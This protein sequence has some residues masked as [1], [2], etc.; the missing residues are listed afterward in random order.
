V[1]DA[2]RAR[3]ATASAGT[4]ACPTASSETMDNFRRPG[5]RLGATL[6]WTSAAVVFLTVTI[7][8]VAGVT[9]AQTA[10]AASGSVVAPSLTASGLQQPNVVSSLP[11]IPDGTVIGTYLEERSDGQELAP[12]SGA[13]I[14]LFREAFLPGTDLF[15]PPAPVATAI[16]GE[17]GFFSF[18]GLQPGSYFLTTIGAPVF[19]PGAVVTITSESGAFSLLTGCT[20]CPP[21]Q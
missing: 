11:V 18:A 4:N 10:P 14:G 16:T 13:T 1:D 12:V 7:T 15:S 21:P 9:S 6:L 2:T 8:G 17:G 3:N 5:G 20:D 19:T